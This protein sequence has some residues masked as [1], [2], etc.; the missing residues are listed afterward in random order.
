MTVRHPAAVASLAAVAA[1]TAAPAV[2]AVVPT[3][4]VYDSQSPQTNIVDF[5]ANTGGTSTATTGAGDTLN[6]FKPAVAT[7]FA[8]NF[9]GVYQFEAP[10]GTGTV[11]GGIQAQYGVDATKTLNI[12]T[13]FRAAGFG[14]STEISGGA[15]G[16]FRSGTDDSGS[17]AFSFDSITGGAAGEQVTRFG[18]TF[19]GRDAAGTVTGVATLSGGGTITKSALINAGAAQD[20][21]FGFDAPA[22]Q[23]LTQVAFTGTGRAKTF[24]DLGFVTA[25]IPA[26]VVPEPSSA[27]AVVAG[28]GLLSLRRRRA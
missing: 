21:F 12:S 5:I 14:T 16:I 23:F 22:G 2:A 25:V 11:P 10:L 28:T 24:D 4:G 20:T 7:A 9:G 8:N 1:L 19:L 6:G 17:G 3:V 27:L 18:L 26:A 13:L 15:E